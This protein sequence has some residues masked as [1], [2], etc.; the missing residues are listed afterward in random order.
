MSKKE[1]RRILNAL[2]AVKEDTYQ[3]TVKK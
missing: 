1:K 2:N 3:E